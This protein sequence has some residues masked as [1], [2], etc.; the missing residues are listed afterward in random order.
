MAIMHIPIFSHSGL[1][2]EDL[3]FNDAWEVYNFCVWQHTSAILGSPWNAVLLGALQVELRSNPDTTK[4]FG[5]N[6]RSSNAIY[7][8]TPEI[9][10]LIRSFPQQSKQW[11]RYWAIG[12]AFEWSKERGDARHRPDKNVSARV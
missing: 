11:R 8:G 5:W 9:T 4:E 1:L 2:F 6:D 12:S 7:S 3:V 10:L